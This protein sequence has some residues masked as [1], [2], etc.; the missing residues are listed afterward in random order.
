MMKMGSPKMNKYRMSK[1]K[2]GFAVRKK[3][4]GK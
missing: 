4:F 3:R 2:S 1:P